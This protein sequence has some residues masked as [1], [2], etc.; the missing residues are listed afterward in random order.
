MHSRG[1]YEAA[2]EFS[3]AQTIADRGT[4]FKFLVKSLGLTHGIVPCFMAK[5]AAGLS[6]NSGHIHISLVDKTSGK[7]L[8]AQEE[9]DEHSPY[10]DLK[11]FSKLGQH[12]TAGILHGLPDI[13]PL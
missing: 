7:N 4:L 13:M 1:V 5:P 11:H 9:A 10:E 12:F 3:D 8:F 2:L 6:G